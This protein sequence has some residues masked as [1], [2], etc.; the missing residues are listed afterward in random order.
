MVKSR[1]VHHGEPSRLR[2]KADEDK[3]TSRESTIESF[4]APV[5]TIGIMNSP[6]RVWAVFSKGEDALGKG[7]HEAEKGGN[8]PTLELG[9]KRRA[10]LMYAL[11]LCSEE[12]VWRIWNEML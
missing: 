7:A 4:G 8:S 3:G 5:G 2:N 12:E 9:K 1:S 11:K 6:S 10:R